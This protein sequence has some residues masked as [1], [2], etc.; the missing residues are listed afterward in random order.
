[1]SRPGWISCSNTNC[2]NDKK[3]HEDWRT[4]DIVCTACGRV[5]QQKTLD[6]SA[7]WRDFDDTGES[8][9]RAERINDDFDQ[10][11]N[12]EIKLKPNRI[13]NRNPDSNSDRFPKPQPIS[14]EQKVLSQASMKIEEFGTRLELPPS[15]LKT[16]KK[17]YKD[18]NAKKKNSEFKKTKVRGKNSDEFMIAVLYIACKEHSLSRTFREL[19][20][21][22]NINESAVRRQYKTLYKQLGSTTSSAPLD[23]S[24]LVIRICSNLNLQKKSLA[25]TAQQIARNVTHRLEGKSPSSIAAACVFM[26]VKL[27]GIQGCTERE[28]A[29]AASITPATVKNIFK[30]MEEMREDILPTEQKVA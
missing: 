30:L 3:F 10:F 12:T 25:Y 1:M 21:Q 19:S 4:G 6:L 17:I 16:A 29:K 13:P 26:A 7:E 28:V 23:P 14:N 5:L 2:L 8:K 24:D 9:S 18:F 20:V 15:V 11:P 27:E 22:T